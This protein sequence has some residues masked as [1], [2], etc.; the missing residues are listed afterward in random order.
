MGGLSRPL[1]SKNFG[2]TPSLRG[3]NDIF[4]DGSG[5]GCALVRN[6]R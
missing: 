2:K 4:T 1:R 6:R 5:R 3:P